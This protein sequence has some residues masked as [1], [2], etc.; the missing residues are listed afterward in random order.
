MFMEIS[1]WMSYGKRKV[2]KT[3]ILSEIKIHFP[4]VLRVNKYVTLSLRSLYLTIEIHFLEKWRPI[5]CCDNYQ[6][7][8]FS[9]DSVT[10]TP[11]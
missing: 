8:I 9:S 11:G 2:F 7:L 4:L 1:R 3:N 6:N 10:L 5:L